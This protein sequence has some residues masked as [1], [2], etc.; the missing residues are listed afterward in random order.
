M[1]LLQ[2]LS[3]C[4][5]VDAGVLGYLDET[6]FSASACSQGTT[7]VPNRVLCLVN[8]LEE[9]DG[10]AAGT[11]SLRSGLSESDLAE[12]LMAAAREIPAN[13]AGSVLHLKAVAKECVDGYLGPSRRARLGGGHN[14]TGSQVPQAMYVNCQR[15]AEHPGRVRQMG[16]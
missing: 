9:P 10:V 7:D 12:V 16:R 1:V 14:T 8:I 6:L 2:R 4:L 15:R 5:V 11:R 13:A 3:C